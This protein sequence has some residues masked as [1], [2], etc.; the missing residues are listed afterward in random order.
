MTVEKCALMAAA[1]GY[2]FFA[3]QWYYECYGGNDITRYTQPGTCDRPCRGDNRQMCGGAC[4]N[5]IYA[6]AASGKAK[7]EECE[8]HQLAPSLSSRG[9]SCLMAWLRYLCCRSSRRWGAGAGW[10]LQQCTRCVFD[11]ATSCWLSA[12]RDGTISLLAVF[13]LSVHAA[14]QWFYDGQRRLHPYLAP[15]KCLDVQAGHTHNGNSLQIWECS[16]AATQVFNANIPNLTPGFL[17]SLEV[18]D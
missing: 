3:L 12:A 18:V 6:L 16:T 5:S 2:K 4:A 11:Q 14:Q 9:L 10:G 1:W 13:L 15:T 7:S 17:G 8:E